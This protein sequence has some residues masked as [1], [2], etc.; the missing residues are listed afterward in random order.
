M[1][2]DGTE[3]MLAYPIINIQSIVSTL[4]NPPWMVTSLTYLL[5][6]VLLQSSLPTLYTSW[7]NA[8]PCFLKT[9]FIYLFVCVFWVLTHTCAPT[10]AHAEARKWHGMFLSIIFYL[11]LWVRMSSW[12]WG[13]HFSRLAGRQQA[14]VT[15]L[16]LSLFRAEIRGVWGIPSLW[17]GCWTLNSHLHDWAAGVFDF[18]TISPVHALMLGWINFTVKYNTANAMTNGWTMWSTWDQVWHSQTWK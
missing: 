9:L 18:Q 6:C 4:G 2:V 15:V 12:T 10:S 13:S 3:A 16:C 7:F 11:F 8:H 17:S 14:P 5:M 1:E